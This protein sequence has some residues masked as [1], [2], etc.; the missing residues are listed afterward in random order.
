MSFQK[1]FL[2]GG[3]T[4]ANQIEGGY[5]EGGK[6]VS[7]ADLV[8]SGTHTSPRRITPAAENDAYYPSHT[9]SDFFHHYEEDIAL[10]GEMGFKCYRMSIAWTRIF[11]TGEED[12]PNEEG[13][14][15]YDRVFDCLRSHGIE[16]LVTLSHYEMPL[17]LVK[18]YNGWVD[19]RLIALFERYVRTVFQR[20]RGKVKYWLT[21]NEINCS[22]IPIGNYSSLGIFNKGT[23]D[24]LHQVDDINL[25]YQALHHQLVAS[26][27]AVI[28]GHEIDPEMKIGNMIAM[29][30]VYPYSCDPD[31]LLLYQEN[32]REVNWYCGDVQVQGEYP[33]YAESFWKKN[34]IH[35]NIT[36]EDLETLKRGTV[37]FYSLSYYQTNCI[38]AHPDVVQASGNLL[39]GAKNPY[40]KAND[41]GWQIDPKGL[42]FTLNEIYSRYRIPIIIVENGLGAKDVLESDGS[43]HDPYRI[44]Y[45][46]EHIKCMK[47]AVELDGVDLFGYT[48][49]GCI[50]LVSCSTGEMAKRYGFIYV[51]IDD[52]GHGSF[53]RYRKDSFYW[54]KKVI[55][56]NGEDLGD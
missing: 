30:P 37:D 21:F 43:I 54:Y 45:L 48:M 3:A 55:A 4:A 42:R 46:R 49:W 19:R 52:A 5:Q 31:D 35:L 2:W 14:R 12:T 6:G 33:F 50:D 38:T 26:A 36:A 56:S 9:A 10:M 13:L 39:G 22:C 20:Y 16:P 27:K 1:D 25:R 24:L 28:A 15:F 41:W 32:W 7:V 47:D 40:L 11:P 18:K 53:D 34:H 51:D 23:T 29:M 8:T 44:E 17:A